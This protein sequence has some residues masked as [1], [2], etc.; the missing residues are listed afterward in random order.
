M[1]LEPKSGLTG[2]LDGVLQGMP[3]ARC[4]IPVPASRPCSGR[5]SGERLFGIS[6]CPR[7][8]IQVSCPSGCVAHCPTMTRS[9]CSVF[10]QPSNTNRHALAA[11]ALFPCHAASWNGWSCAIICWSVPLRAPRPSDSASRVRHPRLVHKGTRLIC[12]SGGVCVLT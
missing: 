10:A 11:L 8:T 5:S 9:S 3:Q 12:P 1:T 2:A 6:V 7:R 4:Y